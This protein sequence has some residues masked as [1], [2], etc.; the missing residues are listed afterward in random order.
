MHGPEGGHGDAATTRGSERRT[1]P[2][3][4]HRS[5]GM[6]LEGRRA[7]PRWLE[8]EWILYEDEALIAVH[9]PAGVPSQEARPGDGDDLPSRVRR[10]LAERAGERSPP[11]LGV[12]QR[13]D[14]ETSGVIVYAK[15]R[16]ANPGLARQLESR[17]VERVYLAGVEGWPGGRS[18]TL[19][20]QHSELGGRRVEVPRGRNDGRKDS[21]DGGEAI[22]HVCER[23]RTGARSL[24][25][26]RIE[27]GSPAS[28]RAR[29]AQAGI[30]IAGDATYGGP[31]APRLMLH[32]ARIALVHPIDGTPLV[33]DAP[34]PPALETW[35]AGR[36]PD[37]AEVFAGALQRRFALARAAL[38]P[39]DRAT[40]AFRLVDEGDGLSGVAVDVYADWAVL[41]LTGPDA[42][43]RQDALADALTA[44]GVSGVYVKRRPRRA[45]VLDAAEIA[46]L[47]PPAPIRGRPAP[48][49]FVVRE[50]GLPFLVRLGDGLSTGLFLDQRENRARV[51]ALAAD[52][53]VLNLFA[54]TC[55]FTVAAAAGGAAESVSVDAGG[56]A[57][58]RGRANLRLASVSEASHRL[59]RAD[60]FEWLERAARRGERF[61]LICCDPPTYSTTKKSR[62]TS[63]KHWMR[64]AALCAAVL[65][66]GGTLLATSHDRRATQRSFRAAI[67]EG[68][69]AAGVELAAL[70]D[71][72]A[73]IDFRPPY[74]EESHLKGILATRAR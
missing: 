22:I 68:A 6:I 72:G 24:L 19:R 71:L 56:P 63:G 62:W 7:V 37:P 15:R 36:E 20:D 69:R 5:E 42:E 34:P 50:H 17:T 46:A 23:A 21:R 43:A 65:A 44:L 8:E 13:L 64:L 49:E 3:S 66:P 10:F 1:P 70:R 28:I 38:A 25:E 4:D 14:R 61:D 29:L 11:Y 39:D 52:K 74:G 48:F 51:R 35:L 2:A 32:A 18:R 53:R 9:K 55:G 16:D 58:E 12:H 40:T 47:A 57:L 54:Y 59:V 27:T 31:P 45:N 60:V 73:P 26:V 67:R 41:H 30:P 33:I